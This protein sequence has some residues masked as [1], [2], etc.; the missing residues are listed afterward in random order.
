MKTVENDG[1]VAAYLDSVDNIRRRK[2]T[3]RVVDM[4]RQITG[5]E[6]R[7]WGDSIVGFGR[8]PYRRSDGSRHQ[9]MLTGVA[10]RK[11]A[12]TV[13]IMP[14]FKPYGELMQQLG[15]H[16]HSISCLYITRLE[17]IDFGVLTE[18]VRVS[19]RDMR[20]KYCGGG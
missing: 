9:W 17:N 12:L 5:E 1:D 20:N 13:Y 7:M 15:R 4:M 8:Y 10:P 6:P 2:E 3:Q 18:L 14:G 11:A 16:R 19:V